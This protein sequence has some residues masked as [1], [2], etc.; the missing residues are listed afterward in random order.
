VRNAIFNSIAALTALSLLAAVVYLLVT[1]ES[2]PKLPSDVL[3]AL[4]NAEKFE[5]ISLEPESYFASLE[6][7]KERFHD[8]VVLG[9]VEITDDAT[10]ERLTTAFIQNASEG[11]HEVACWEPRH[12]LRVVHAGRTLELLICF[13]CEFVHVH[14][15]GDVIHRFQIAD[16]PQPVFDE[17]LRKAN[18]KLAWPG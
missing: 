18:V 5:L 12:G 7:S 8:W 13:K 17:V 10:R 1:S 3:E 4:H 11:E 2:R 14:F 6:K 9:S 16:S 15:G